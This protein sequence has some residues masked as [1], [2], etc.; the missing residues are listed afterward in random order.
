MTQP[1]P[2]QPL[3][4]TGARVVDGTGAAPTTD[5][6]LTTDAAGI[7]T[8]VGPAAGAPA[9]APDE[10][11]VA[12]DGRTLLPGFLDTHVHFGYASVGRLADELAVRPS[13]AVLESARR[14]REALHAGVTTARDLGGLDAGFREA[15][16]RGLI[17]G[18]RMRVAVRILSHTGGHGDFRLPTGVDLG[19]LTG[20]SEIADTVDEARAATRKVLHEGAD[21]IKL[22]ATG[23]V[24]SPS[25]QPDDEGLTQEEI[26]AVVDEARRHGGRPVAAHAQ[27]TAG[28]LSA[29]RGGVTSIEHGYAVDERCIDEMLDRG[30]YLVPTL[31]TAMRIPARGSVPDYL[32]EKKVRWSALARERIALAIERGVTIALGT[33]SGVC[34]HGR[35]LE[36]LGHL[37]D[38]GLSP[39][40]ALQAGTR[41]AAELLGLADVLGTLEPGKHA[42]LV[43]CA[44]DPLTDIS[45]LADPTN[46]L[47]VAQNGRIVK[48]TGV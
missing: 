25:D 14:M 5:A 35:N 42:D 46:V 45:C 23:G 38:L 16:E 44:G 32:Y 2:G 37:T 19:R 26:A 39:V 15:V 24:S 11:V 47:L 20:L 22:C 3:R 43:V 12:L 6:V 28:V 7:I 17:E 33:D 41:N 29:V 9:P 31:S 30:T 4:I 21:V 27:G 36:E 34:P 10:H 18:P 8:Y 40:Q 13:V 48:R 1:T